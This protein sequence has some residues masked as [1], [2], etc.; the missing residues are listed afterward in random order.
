MQTGRKFSGNGMQPGRKFS[1]N[2]MQPGIHPG[3]HPGMQPPVRKISGSYKMELQPQ[4]GMQKG[5]NP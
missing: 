2:G 3:M 5:K 1:G 4:P